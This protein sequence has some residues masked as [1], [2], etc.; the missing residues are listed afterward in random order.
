MS[1][2]YNLKRG[3]HF[4]N[5]C[6]VRGQD[7]EL[8]CTGCSRVHQSVATGLGFTKERIPGLNPLNAPLLGSYWEN[9]VEFGASTAGQVY[10]LHVDNLYPT[11]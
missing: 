5:T 11:I 10:L 8:K 3:L 2:E 1:P 4:T 9:S 7:M 6:P